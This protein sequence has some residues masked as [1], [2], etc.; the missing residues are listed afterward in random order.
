MS[1]R[2]RRRAGLLWR[3][4]GDRVVVLAPGAEQPVVLAGL[5]AVVWHATVEPVDAD[6]LAA[7]LAD[8][9]LGPPDDLARSLAG[10]LEDLGAHG[11]LEPC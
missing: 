3:R 2:W 9:D 10:T 4:A 7:E 11:V 8:L 5:A 1:R 6:G